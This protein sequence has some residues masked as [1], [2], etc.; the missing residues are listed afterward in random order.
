MYVIEG[1]DTWA[2]STIRVAEVDCSEKEVG[3]YRAFSLFVQLAMNGDLSAYSL[4]D[5][6]WNMVARVDHRGIKD[7]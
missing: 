4:F 1:E 2:G 3:E 6:D 7:V 5:A